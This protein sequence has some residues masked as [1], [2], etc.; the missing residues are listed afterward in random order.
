MAEES[1]IYIKLIIKGNSKQSQ[2]QEA[3]RHFGKISILSNIR[4]DPVAIYM[5]YKQREE[6]EQAFDA[7]K[8]KL[9]NDKTYLKW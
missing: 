2:F 7:T 4:D 1:S 8:N 3:S 6:V 5:I 9:E